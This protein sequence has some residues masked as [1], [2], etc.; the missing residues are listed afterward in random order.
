MREIHQGSKMSAVISVEEYLDLEFDDRSAADYVDGEVVERA[1]PTPV[2]S[3]I[4]ALLTLFFA[5]LLNRVR[6]ILMSELHVQIEPRVFRV[7]DFAVY[8]DQRPEGRYATTSQTA[9][10]TI[11]AGAFHMFGS[12]IL[13]LSACTNTR[14]LACSSIPPFDCLNSISKSRRKSFSKISS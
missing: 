12:W 10:K 9:W 4:Q 1:L 11:A 14:T 6:L 3:Y 2:H 5:P 13:S 8:R 7:V